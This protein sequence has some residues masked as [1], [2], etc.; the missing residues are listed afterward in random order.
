MP[1]HLHLSF[2]LKSVSALLMPATLNKIVAEFPFS[3]LRSDVTLR[4]HALDFTEPPLLERRYADP[5]EIEEPEF[6][7]E[8]TAYQL[9]AY[10]ELW[11]WDRDWS[12]APSPV[13]LDI[14]GPAFD[15]P[16]GEQVKIDLGPEDLFLPPPDASAG[17]R[18]VQ[19]NLQSVLHL[20]R[21]LEGVLAVDKRLLWSDSGEDFASK[22]AG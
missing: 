3:K 18:P 10:W 14:Y 20:M 15:S 21:D 17:L 1:D 19:S 13:W 11:I 16:N 7:H 2:W 6:K 8:D 5:S 12:L 4:V 9:E 22:L